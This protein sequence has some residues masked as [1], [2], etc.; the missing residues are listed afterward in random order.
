MDVLER[1]YKKLPDDVT[2]NIGV[3]GWA[4][5][6]AHPKIRM[7]FAICQEQCSFKLGIS[8]QALIKPLIFWRGNRAAPHS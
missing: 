2:K 1:H 3:S 4:L 7:F 8:E 6:R 5:T